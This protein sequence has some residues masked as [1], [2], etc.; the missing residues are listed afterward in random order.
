[1]A[2]PTTSVLDDFNRAN[3]NLTASANWGTGVY[4]FGDTTMTISSNK[5][6]PGSVTSNWYRNYWQAVTFGPDCEVYAT[7]SAAAAA[8]HFSELSARLQSPATTGADAYELEIGWTAGNEDVLVY[9]VVNDVFTTLRNTVGGFGALAAGDKVGLEVTGA[10]ATV[11]LRVYKFTAGSWAQIGTDLADANAARIVAAGNIAVSHQGEVGG[12]WDDFGGGTIVTG[13]ATQVTGV[14]A[15][16]SAEAFGTAKIRRWLGP[17]AVSTG[18]AFGAAALRRLLA[19]VGVASGE[20]FG[21]PRLVRWVGPGGTASLEAFGRPTILGGIQGISVTGAGA[22]GSLEAFGTP[23]LR[24]ILAAAAI[25]SGEAFGTAKTVRF[26]GPAGVA[27]AQSLGSPK[28]LRRLAA[29]GVASAEAFGTGRIVR[30]LAVVNIASGEAFGVAT[31]GPYVP[32]DASM[33]GSVAL[34]DFTPISVVV[35]DGETYIVGVADVVH[36]DTR[37]SDRPGG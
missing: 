35:A 18:E 16:A 24:R 20:Q 33:A 28:L 27:S 29:A 15:I 5:A 37:I 1:M 36:V 3:A 22:I 13:G 34:A 10:G 30:Y 11:T 21:T 23:A 2:F 7:I 32:A 25:G 26:L 8:G 31:L 6:I 14:G 9:R 17:G 19:A 12:A 4:G